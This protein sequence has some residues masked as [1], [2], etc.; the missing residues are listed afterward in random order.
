MTVSSYSLCGSAGT[1]S[2]LHLA[3]SHLNLTA[4]LG[5]LHPLHSGHRTVKL[6]AQDHTAVRAELRFKPRSSE[7]QGLCLLPSSSPNSS[8]QSE[9]TSAF[10]EVRTLVS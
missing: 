10:K 7:L 6:L 9:P 4:N 2:F 8:L 3:Y 5:E 1:R